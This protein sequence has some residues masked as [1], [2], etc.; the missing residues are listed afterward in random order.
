ML[1]T[2]ISQRAAAVR[3]F[4]RFYTRQI[5]LLAGHYLD[6]PFSLSEARVIYELA[7]RD[8][9]TATSL[10][11]ELGLDPGY[12]S[13]MLRGFQRRGLLSKQPSAHDGRQSLLRLTA[14]GRRAFQA[15]NDRSQRDLE[16][17]L[18]ALPAADQSRLV[19]AMQAIEGLLAAPAAPAAPAT[20]AAALPAMKPPAYVL[21]PPRPGD[22]GWVVARHGA[23]YAQEYGWDEQFEAL[24]A[25]IVAKFVQEFDPRRE[26][27]WIAEMDG[28]NAGSVFLV[29]KSDTVAKLRLLLVEPRARGLGL[30]ARLV[31][32]C[33]RFARQAGYR[34]MTL[35]TNSV[36]LAARHI[37][38]R[39]GFKL[40]ESGPHHSFGHDLVEETWLLEL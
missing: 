10:V 38:V 22:M 11:R 1:P 35:W 5:G 20:T 8:T 3:R 23:L 24:V 33:L 4:N 32:E 18:S 14:K 39:A 26:R 36:L 27:C 15:L 2:E 12:L 21:R 17:M 13:R 28:E 31:E 7:Q 6:S 40:V 34:Q 19:G 16:A 30:G 9:D 29:K 25:E 37:Y